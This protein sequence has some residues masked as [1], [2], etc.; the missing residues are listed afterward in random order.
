MNTPTPT[1]SPPTAPARDRVGFTLIELLVVISIIA[2]L[3]G[4]LLPAL[5]GARS[6]ARAAVCLS[7][8]RQIAQAGHAYAVDNKKFLFPGSQMYG[9]TA[10]FVT[11]SRG[12]YLDQDLVVHRCP[13]D[14]DENDNWEDNL[15]GDPV[16]TTSY[17]IN[18]YFAPNHD[19]YGDP[20]LNFGGDDNVVGEKGI[21][22]E[23]VRNPSQ[24]IVVAEVAEYKDRDHFMPMYW[25]TTSPLHPNTSTPM[26]TM[27][28]GN[29]R[30]GEIDGANGNV[31]RSIVRERHQNAP[32][33]AFA[34][35]HGASHAFEETWDDTIADRSDRDNNG[36]TDWYDPLY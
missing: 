19:P 35:G 9:G 25:G 24:K 6:A 23:N 5:G 31:P 8:Q 18:G 36:K 26:A 3:I 33:F 20:P 30:N 16:R 4:I 1:P 14:L 11:L 2:L 21:A 34:D 32:R 29:A 27:M 17:A 12:G 7:N 10:Y 15:L 13:A 22:M 28:T